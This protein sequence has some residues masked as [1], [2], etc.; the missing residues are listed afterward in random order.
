[1]LK[2]KCHSV[3]TSERNGLNII[4]V[5]NMMFTTAF[6][7][8]HVVSTYQAPHCLRN[9]KKLSSSIMK[10]G[11]PSICKTQITFS[12]HSRRHTP[13]DR[14]VNVH[15][16]DNFRTYLFKSVEQVSVLALLLD[17]LCEGPLECPFGLVSS[18]W[19]FGTALARSQDQECM[20]QE[21]LVTLRSEVHVA[22]GTCDATI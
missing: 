2:S 17:Q 19:K 15:C 22:G 14:K 6:T 5:R 10:Y 9:Q 18:Y 1:M 4:S 11:A 20:W 3:E 21:G 12:L 13:E 8:Q 16:L 7:V